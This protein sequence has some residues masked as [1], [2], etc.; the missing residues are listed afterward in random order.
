MVL[1]LPF[2]KFAVSTEYRGVK[3]P[4]A[5]RSSKSRNEFPG[6]GT[7]VGG[8]PA[9]GTYIWLAQKMLLY[10]AVGMELPLLSAFFT[11]TRPAACQMVPLAFCSLVDVVMF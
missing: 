11:V 8:A 4:L 1:L 6:A 10:S 9:C 3:V 2:P 7:S 5:P